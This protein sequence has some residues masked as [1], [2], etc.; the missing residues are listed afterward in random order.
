MQWK[1]WTATVLQTTGTHSTPDGEVS[2]LDR[3]GTTAAAVASCWAK[4]GRDGDGLDACMARGGAACPTVRTGECNP[5]VILGRILP[6]G[7]VSTDGLPAGWEATA[8]GVAGLPSVPFLGV[9]GLIPI[10]YVVDGQHMHCDES[11][12]WCVSSGDT[13]GE[14]TRRNICEDPDA[15]LSVKRIPAPA[16]MPPLYHPVFAERWPPSCLPEYP[17]GEWSRPVHGIS[18]DMVDMEPQWPTMPPPLPNMG[19]GRTPSH[20]STGGDHTMML[21]AGTGVLRFDCV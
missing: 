20:V 4:Y 9:D 1:I 8:A 15:P 17:V 6:D 11:E 10:P 13:Y 12:L 3:T 14:H 18:L 21:H 5:A 16:T 7:T 19:A 2:C